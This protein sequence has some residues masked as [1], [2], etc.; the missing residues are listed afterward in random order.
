MN[1]EF[2]TCHNTPALYGVQCHYLLDWFVSQ[3]VLQ[4]LNDAVNGIGMD[5]VYL[6]N[7]I[8]YPIRHQRV[9]L[10]VTAKSTQTKKKRKSKTVSHE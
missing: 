1:I 9:P 10:R 6:N 2:L 5:H 7:V 4:R 3:D 8:M